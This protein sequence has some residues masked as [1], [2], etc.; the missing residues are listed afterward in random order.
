M[1]TRVPVKVMLVP[2]PVARF[3]T[4]AVPDRPAASSSVRAVRA[5]PPVL[6]RFRSIV[7]AAAA[8]ARFPTVVVVRGVTTAAMALPGRSEAPRGM[9]ALTM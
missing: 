9:T 3:L 7:A 4:K 8:M 5:L 6:T 2:A 1:R